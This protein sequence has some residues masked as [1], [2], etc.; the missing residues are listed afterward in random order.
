MHQEHS[1]FEIWNQT[2]HPLK[3]TLSDFGYVHPA[4]PGVSNLDSALNY[5]ISVLYPAAKSAVANP[6]ALPAVGNTIGDYRVVL[7]D[8]DGKS[9]GYRWEQREGEAAASWHKILDMDW[10]TDSIL[11]AVTDVTM[12][13]YVVRHGR[14]DLDENGDVI[15]G[16]YAG[17]KIYGGTEAN[18][19]LTLAANSGDGVGPHTGYVQTDDNFR[20]TINNT[21]DLGTATEKFKTGYFGTSLNV[22]TLTFSDGL[23]TSS[24]GQI[25]FDNENLLTTGNITGVTG[26]FTTSIEVGALAGDALILGPG[27]ITDESG[28]ISF[29]NENISTTGTLGSGVIT[30][31]ENAQTLI[32]DPDIVGDKASI[33]SSRGVISFDNENLEGTGNL[34]FTDGIFTT[35]KGGNLKLAVNTLSSENID[36]N[37]ILLPNGTGIVDV[38][39]TLQTIGITT[40]GTH[41]ITGQLNVDNI[42]ID[43]N[44]I[45]S[46][47]INGNIQLDPNGSGYID[48]LSHIIPNSDDTYNLGDQTHR[49]STLYVSDAIHDGTLSIAISTLMSLRDI[50]TGATSGMTI[51]YDGSKWNASIPDTEV[52]HGSVSGLSD[53]DHTQYALLAGRAGGQTLIGGAAASQNL[54]LQS[55]ANATRGVIKFADSMEPTTNA[56]YSGGWAGSDI[57]GSSYYF[58]DLYMKGEAKGLR[59]ENFTSGTLP[60]FSANNVGRILYAT[61]TKKAYVDTGTAIAVLG[62]SKF[63]SDTSWNGSDTTKDIDVSSS[64]SDARNAIWAL[65]DN[66]NDFE[67][68]YCSIK[69]TS[70]ANV[71]ITVSPALPAGSYRLIGLE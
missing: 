67:R 37:I 53:D 35:V 7:D 66:A 4:L 5:I 19:N 12:E 40:T 14:Q 11:A 27:S 13:M 48:V 39:K 34:S 26:Y 68:I 61:D 50:L 64:I 45:S 56:S 47:D 21:Y 55:T 22:A 62:V 71:R 52:D 60:A 8:G 43:G 70:A 28:F 24:T 59:L 16:L 3:H 36:G 6:G 30:V 33:T 58:R 69:A 17:Q 51:F 25:S 1:R 9:A 57:G 63:V 2:Q 10:S 18:Q 41:G 15:V 31:T 49:Y 38:Q 42:R 20:P 32:F 29:G 65:H 44:V 46:T 54:I 23:I